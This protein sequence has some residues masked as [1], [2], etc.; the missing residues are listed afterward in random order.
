M[1]V[2]LPWLEFT[3][4]YLWFGSMIEHKALIGMPIDEACRF[5][6]LSFVDENIVG[7]V[8]ACE[9]LDA[10]IKLWPI[11]ISVGFSLS[12]VTEANQDSGRR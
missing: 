10:A 8:K 11:K 6:Q 4:R 7:Q 2:R 12:D 5:Y 9:L 1:K 3:H